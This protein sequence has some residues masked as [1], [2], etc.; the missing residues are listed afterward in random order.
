M[1]ENRLRTGMIQLSVV[2]VEECQMQQAAV[3]WGSYQ[4][5]LEHVSTAVECQ[6]GNRESLGSNPL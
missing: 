3:S 6:T 4:V 5:I 1:C 2:A